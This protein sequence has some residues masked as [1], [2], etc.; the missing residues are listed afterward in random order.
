MITSYI[1]Y[2]H[3]VFSSKDMYQYLLLTNQETETQRRIENY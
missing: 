2:Y 1:Y 3:I